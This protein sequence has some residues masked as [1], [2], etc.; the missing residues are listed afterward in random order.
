MYEVP[1][2]M[3]S[4]ILLSLRNKQKRQS[5]LNPV[6]TLGGEPMEFAKDFYRGEC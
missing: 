4:D 1:K 6:Y 5:V 2:T 3:S